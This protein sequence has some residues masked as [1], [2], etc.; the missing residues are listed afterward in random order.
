MTTTTSITNSMHTVKDVFGVGS[1][2]AKIPVFSGFDRVPTA[3]ANFV[4][5]EDQVQILITWYFKGGT[6]G[7]RNLLLWGPHGSGKTELIR[8]FCA[9]IRV[10]L[11]EDV[12]S[13]DRLFMDYV[14]TFLPTAS[15]P[16]M[17]DSM[18]V[19]SMRVPHAV[20]LMNEADALAQDTMLALNNILDKGVLEN[21]STS[22]KV[23]A[24]NGWRFVGT[25]NTNMT[26]DA[27]GSYKGTKKQSAATASRFFMYPCSY[28]PE[29][30]EKKV[31][32]NYGADPIFIEG[33]VRFANHTR[34]AFMDG[35]VRSVMTTREL[36]MWTQ[37]YGALHKSSVFKSPRQATLEMSFMSKCESRDKMALQQ[38][39]RDLFSD[40]YVG[41]QL[42]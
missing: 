38:A 34:K 4:F 31:L 5:R 27:H 36:V 28:M 41:I 22:E 1:A 16:R 13:S 30:L 19:K 25:S 17:V 32:E 11:F 29:D 37:Q 6:A 9:R 23:V 21:P 10:P 26:G 2:T 39:Y 8:Q 14:G 15:G 7:M 40:E 12:G 24:A 18:L 3:D 42:T 33:A 35:T 20:F